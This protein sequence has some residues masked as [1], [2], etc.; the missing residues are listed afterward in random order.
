MD[1]EGRRRFA[2]LEGGIEGFCFLGGENA[3]DRSS[4]GVELD[5]D[6]GGDRGM[7]GLGGDLLCFC[8]VGLALQ[9]DLRRAANGRGAGVVPGA[10]FGGRRFE[11]QKRGGGGVRGRREILWGR[12]STDSDGS[13]IVSK[14]C[15]QALLFQGPGEVVFPMLAGMEKSHQGLPAVAGG[16]QAEA[17]VGSEKPAQGQASPGFVHA[18]ETNFL[19]GVFCG[20]KFGAKEPGDDAAHGPTVRGP[21]VSAL[22]NVLQHLTPQAWAN[23]QHASAVEPHAGGVKTLVCTSRLMHW[24]QGF[25][26]EQSH[27]ESRGG[28]QFSPELGQGNSELSWHQDPGAHL[29]L[30]PP[31]LAPG[32]P[33]REVSHRVHKAWGTQ[34]RLSRSAVRMASRPILDALVFRRERRDKVEASE[35]STVHTVS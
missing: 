21:G 26:Q 6:G 33:L 25:Q 13:C 35:G 23:P 2:G 28:V 9:V 12:R 7:G 8:T 32:P 11:G 20:G 10:G 24:R 15:A 27:G 19:Q 31:G 34:C 1:G 16:K 3:C 22:C 18:V 29:V 17:V 14:S 4:G 30:A 5:S